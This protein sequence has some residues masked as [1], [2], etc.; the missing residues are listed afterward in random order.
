MPPLMDFLTVD[1]K[2][3]GWAS[4]RGSVMVEAALLFPLIIM[5]I[6]LIFSFAI[7]RYERVSEQMMNL[8]EERNETLIDGKQKGEEVGYMRTLDFVMEGVLKGQ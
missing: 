4:K 6:L 7:E 3:P 2:L 5:V 1:F 8:I